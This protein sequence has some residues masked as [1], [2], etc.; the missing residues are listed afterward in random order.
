MIVETG[1][2]IEKTGRLCRI[3]LKRTDAC[4]GCHTCFFSNNKSYMVA[5]AVTEIDVKEGDSVK[6]QRINT[7]GTKAGFFMFIL[8]LIF[9]MAGFNLSSFIITSFS[10]ITINNDITDLINILI[11]ILFFSFP[12][13]ILKLLNKED[14]FQMKIISKF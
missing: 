2:V 10:I 3:K 1:T 8:P 4:E 5:E 6:I 11:G 13:I 12:L 9:F 7:S 14:A